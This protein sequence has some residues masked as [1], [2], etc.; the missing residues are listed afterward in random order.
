MI[1]MLL[2]I[3]FNKIIMMLK[4]LYMCYMI[5][6]FGNLYLN[7]FIQIIQTKLYYDIYVIGYCI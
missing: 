7:N 5:S 6:F 1:Y 3:V 2:V 4:E